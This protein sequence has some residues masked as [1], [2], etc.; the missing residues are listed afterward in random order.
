MKKFWNWIR[1]EDSGERVL[2]LEGP[3]DADDVWGDSITPKAF[4]DELESDEGD[5]TVWINSPGGSVF[6]AAEIYTMLCDYKGHVKV[7][8]ASV[9]A[10]AASVIAMAGEKVQMSPTAL[11]MIH[12]P[13]TFAMGNARDM[14]KAISTLNEV[15]ESIINAYQRKTGL[16]RNKIAKLMEDETWLN[17]K[18]AVQMGFADEVLFENT[19]KAGQEPDTEDVAD[20]EGIIAQEGADAVERPESSEGAGLYSSRGMGRVILNRIYPD[21]VPSFA[22]EEDDGAALEPETVEPAEEGLMTEDLEESEFCDSSLST[23][24]VSEA[25]ET[26]PADLAQVVKDSMEGFMDTFEGRFLEAL[27]AWLDE[28]AVPAVAT[29][30][31]TI[32]EKKADPKEDDKEDTDDPEE[33]DDDD[34]TKKKKGT[35]DKNSASEPLSL[36]ADGKTPDGDMPFELL[37][38]Q[39]E[40]LR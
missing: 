37:M 30:V 39:L 23:D 25:H 27:G 20:G 2:R 3:V 19:P 12:D 36:G 6:A 29:A 32:M 10:S 38:S 28:R 5:I 35:K 16:S 14:E 8:I 31:E 17:A 18:K 7:K 33:D 24:L 40:F 15:K 22:A 34:D 11:L 4:R 21:G 1:N 9:A 13:M 26:G